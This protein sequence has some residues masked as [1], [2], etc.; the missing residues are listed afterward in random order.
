MKFRLVLISDP[1]C[2][3][4]CY[5]VQIQILI[6]TK[7]SIICI[8]LYINQTQVQ[9][10]TPKS[11]HSNYYTKL[12]IGGQKGQCS[13][14]VA[15]WLMVLGMAGQSIDNLQCLPGC[16][17]DTVFKYG[18]LQ[19]LPTSI[20]TLTPTLNPTYLPTLHY[21]TLKMVYYFNLT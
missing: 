7:L 2:I 3:S 11:T 19:I 13:S 12:L 17:L 10:H 9:I 1:N 14:L 20:A 4:L 6:S 21:I 5:Q 15:H 16:L 8:S 18:L